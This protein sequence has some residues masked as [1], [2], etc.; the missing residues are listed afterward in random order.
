M[1]VVFLEMTRP[2][3]RKRQAMKRHNLGEHAAATSTNVRKKP[4]LARA[5]GLKY[6]A[7]AEMSVYR[8]YPANQ[9][10]EKGIEKCGGSQLLVAPSIKAFLLWRPAAWRCIRHNAAITALLHRRRLAAPG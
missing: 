6:P 2:R 7:S 9:T 1:F 4:A 3:A 5:S 8:R 10:A